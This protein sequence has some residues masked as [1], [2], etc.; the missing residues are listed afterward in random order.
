[1]EQ[2]KH[3]FPLGMATDG[4]ARLALALLAALALA[5]CAATPAWAANEPGVTL[6]TDAQGTEG[7]SLLRGLGLA[8]SEPA[9]LTQAEGKQGTSST[10]TGD[11][12]VGGPVLLCAGDALALGG[13]T[14]T[15]FGDLTIAGA[16]TVGSGD[17]V[18]H[19][20]LLVD[21]GTLIMTS[22]TGAATVDGAFVT[23]GASH[24]GKLSAG[25]LTVGGDFLQLATRSSLSYRETGS[26]IT[27]LVGKNKLV[28]FT[29][30]VG[31]ALRNPKLS[32]VTFTAGSRTVTLTRCREQDGEIVEDTA[33][34][35]TTGGSWLALAPSLTADLTITAPHVWLRAAMNGHAITVNGAATV[36][37][38]GVQH[39][40]GNLTAT[41]LT[42][43]GTLNLASAKTIK[44]T[45]TLRVTGTLNQS[46][47]TVDCGS[48]F[49]AAGGTCTLSGGALSLR[50]GFSQGASAVVNA[51]AA[52]TTTLRAA[53][54][55]VS[56]V[57]PA[58]GWFGGFALASGASVA[59]GSVLSLRTTLASNLA[60]PAG[61]DL[62]MA[63]ATGGRRLTVGGTLTV[64]AGATLAVEAGRVVAGALTVDGTLA[65][66]QSGGIVDVAGAF[67]A[68]GADSTG[69]LTAGWLILRG[70]FA[71]RAN[72]GVTT[73]FR[74]GAN[75][76]TVLLGTGAQSIAFQNP[77][78]SGF[79]QLYVANAA[80][81]TPTGLPAAS[82]QVLSTALDALTV[83][84]GD[85]RALTPAFSPAAT[86]YEALIPYGQTTAT[87]GWAAAAGQLVS[88][89]VDGV[90]QPV[91]WSGT[92]AIDPTTT[93]TVTLTVSALATLPTGIDDGRLR[94]V[95]T[96]TLSPVNAELSSLGLPAGTV[97]GAIDL[98]HDFDYTATLPVGTAKVKVAPQ[99]ANANATVAL[100]AD[101]VA[102]GIPANLQL[103]EG[104]TL[105]LRMAVTA[106]TTAND[107][108]PAEGSRVYTVALTRPA[109]LDGLTA[110]SPDGVVSGLGF[111]REKE[112]YTLLVS[113][114]VETVTLTATPGSGCA[115]LTANGT[116]S[117]SITLKPAIGGSAKG[118]FVAVDDT[119][120]YRRTYTVTV[121]RLVL[122]TGMALLADEAPVNPQPAFAS[123]TS[124]YTVDLHDDTS[125]VTARLWVSTDVSTLTLNGDAIPAGQN[126]PLPLPGLGDATSQAVVVARTHNGKESRY[127][128][129]LRRPL[130]T[131]VKVSTGKVSGGFQGY[132]TTIVDL[133]YT[134]SSVTIT[135]K[136]VAG[137]TMVD[138]AGK[139]LQGGALTVRPAMGTSKSVTLS[140]RRSDGSQTLRLT[141]RR[142]KSNNPALTTLG[143]SRGSLSPAF[144]AG[145][146]R[147]TLTLPETAKNLTF[148]PKAAVSNSTWRVNGGTANHTTAVTLPAVGSDRAVA[149]AVKAQDGTTRT[150]TVT[151]RVRKTVAAI[152]GSPLW[153]GRPSLSP[154]GSN[155][156]TLAYTLAQPATVKIQVRKSGSTTYRTLKTRTH[157]TGGAKTWDWDGTIGSGFAA[158]GTWY[159]RVTPTVS[160]VTGTSRTLAVRVL[161]KPTLTLTATATSLTADGSHRF[162]VKARWSV[163][164]DVRVKVV[165]ASGTTVR[166]LWAKADRQ[167]DSQTLYWDGRDSKGKLVK[168]G[169]YTVGLSGG[170]GTTDKVKVTVKRSSAVG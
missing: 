161:A 18:V 4:A 22:S 51:A 95:T 165:N 79:G 34:Y 150:Y 8:G 7:G 29:T 140:A 168:A 144:A 17:L 99:A 102:R 87:V 45:G 83:T 37:K 78:D 126:V 115:S 91:G 112:S 53:G 47:G 85:G 93:R 75:H 92:V 101:G 110:T 43:D 148:T 56:F 16:L 30:P 46:T 3:P 128:L 66:T 15:V 162:K 27:K 81:A 62:W 70:G 54:S 21:G 35:A 136:T 40:T 77:G 68:R 152:A 61:A 104:Q 19:G 119:G 63:G 143:Q 107:P 65:M 113:P 23:D 44:T 67:T 108:T 11:E 32:G 146:T 41:T 137:V 33:Q 94:R 147:Y 59:P 154:G 86:A 142:A 36:P 103:A 109:L 120:D 10:L 1:M 58:K 74:A 125:L 49:T 139:A 106:R 42:V 135:P 123:T 6:H 114:S 31:S 122:V 55:K 48:T 151:V 38:G 88:A 169:T 39:V 170:R 133:P 131:G 124:A 138:S 14:L 116:A 60:L 163:L 105:A 82:E 52:H 132:G 80:V 13:N 167:P 127:T 50:S 64:P 149:I 71:Q 97:Q 160:G 98:A 121:Q 159:L 57:A 164:T 73:T 5:L 153:D 20:N 129:T 89:A 25:T 76:R 12:T 155:D 158:A 28:Q 130:V 96:L 84:A 100:R 145:T 111:D 26:H 118:T 156:M 117:S 69:K 157:T 24:D 2:R 90:T 134:T 141:V 9:A 72:G 166:T